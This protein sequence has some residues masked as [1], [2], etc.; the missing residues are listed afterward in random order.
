ML[1]FSLLI[2]E[3]LEFITFDISVTDDAK[4]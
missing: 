3:I 4:D 1:F 2:C